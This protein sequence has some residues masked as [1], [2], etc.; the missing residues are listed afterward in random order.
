MDFDKDV[1]RREYLPD[2]WVVLEFRIPAQNE[3]YYRVFAG[4]GGGYLDGDSWKLNSGI[5]QVKEEKKVW[6]FVGNSGSVYRCRKSGYG[7][8]GYMGSVLETWR[9]TSVDGDTLEIEILPEDYD[10]MWLNDA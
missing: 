6:L 4:W 3:T 10:F 1:E 2:R 7:M 8:T 9:K 5:V